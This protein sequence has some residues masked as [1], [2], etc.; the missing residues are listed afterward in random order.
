MPQYLENLE[1]LEKQAFSRFYLEN[2][3]K[4]VLFRTIF[5]ENK[6]LYI[7][8]SLEV[9]FICNCLYIFLEVII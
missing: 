8:N 1:I 3:E 4:Y 2:L 5:L 7:N 6:E 9:Y